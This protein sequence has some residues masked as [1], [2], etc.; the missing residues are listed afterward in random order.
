M[1]VMCKVRPIEIDRRAAEQLAQP[2]QFLVPADKTSQPGRQ[3]VLLVI[4]GGRRDFLPQHRLLE[5]A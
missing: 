5:L 1:E 3:V 2:Y 4:Q